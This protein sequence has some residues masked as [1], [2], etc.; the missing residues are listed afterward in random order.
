MLKVDDQ[1]GPTITQSFLGSGTKTRNGSEVEFPMEGHEPRAIGIG[2]RVQF[3]KASVT[4]GARPTDH[5]PLDLGM[6]R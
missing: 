6:T 1:V 3:H 2:A 5:P 4:A